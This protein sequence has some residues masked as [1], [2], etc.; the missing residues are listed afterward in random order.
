MEKNEM[1]N[2]LNQIHEDI[3]IIKYNWL[4]YD[5]KLQNDYYA[6]SYWVLNY[7]YH[8]DLESIS[9]YITEHNDKGVDCFV[10]FED[11]KELYIIQN[12]YYS[13]KSY[14]K[15]EI[16]SDFLISPLEFLSKGIYTRSPLLQDIY[17]KIKDDSDYTIYLYCY[18]TKTL[19]NISKDILMLFD[20]TFAYNFNVEARLFDLSDIYRIYNG[21]RY[22]EKKNFRYDIKLVTKK[23]LIDQ[24]SEQH[25]KEYGVDTAYVAVNVCEIFNMLAKSNIE[26]YD[27]FDKNIREYLGIKGK[28]GKT[29]KEIQKTLLNPIERNRFFY[30]NNGVTMICD[31]YDTWSKS[32]KHYLKVEQPQIVNGCQTVNTI[33]NTIEEFSKDKDWGEVISAFKN[34]FILVK[35]FKVNKTDEE[36]RK[37]YEN[38]VRFT[39]T[40]TGITSKDFASKDNY[41]LTLQDDFLKYGFYLIVKQSDRHKYSYDSN[42]EFVKK[43]SIN[44]V[45]LFNKTINQPSDLFID[46]DKMLKAISAFYF[47]GYT[48]FKYGSSTLKETS[49]KYYINFS[50]DIRSFLT[51][52]N[53]INLYLLYEKSGGTLTGRKQRYPIPYYLMD[54]VG[55]FIK[56]SDISDYDFDKVNNKL[57][58]LFSSKEVFEE[59]YDKFCQI[60]EDYADDFQETHNVDYSTMTKNHKIDCDLLDKCLRQ[61]CKEAN[62]NN[63]KH[64]LEY[65][66]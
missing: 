18:V 49:L 25:N 48:A 10:H 4:E 22:E 34:C 5:S 12:F 47:D 56:L 11:S 19:N 55:R 57:L 42:F 52:N 27:L 65:I 59:I 43:R 2:F 63:W 38:I 41:F 51:P 58:Y 35:I 50:K 44:K 40:Q 46:L 24:R 33:Y 13:E 3:E 66:S 45:V 21:E 20:R 17:N 54:F 26:S 31:D 23:E 37:I 7:L 60:V 28:K 1:K 6:F 61:K 29:N 32:N 16:I 62:R 30:Y 15:R 64:F 36:E 9:D 53:M 14:L 39:N 8:V